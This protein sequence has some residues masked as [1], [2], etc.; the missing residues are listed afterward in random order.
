[1]VRTST[2]TIKPACNKIPWDLNVFFFLFKSKMYLY[3][4]ASNSTQTIKQMWM[5]LVTLL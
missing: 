3:I 1:M 4:S 5:K 2:H